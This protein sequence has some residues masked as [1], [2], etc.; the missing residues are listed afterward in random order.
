M[1]V[2]HLRLLREEYLASLFCHIEDALDDSPVCNPRRTD[3]LCQIISC[4]RPGKL[5][6]ISAVESQM[7]WIFANT[8]RTRA[9]HLRTSINSV[10]VVKETFPC[11]HSLMKNPMNTPTVTHVAPGL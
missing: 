5:P 9:Y 4:A 3:P 10:L 6:V 2:I 11:P 1:L 7:A 8:V